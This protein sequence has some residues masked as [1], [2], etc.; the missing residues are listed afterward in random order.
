[1]NMFPS[2]SFSAFTK[3]LRAIGSRKFLIQRSSIDTYRRFSSYSSFQ[4]DSLFIRDNLEKFRHEHQEFLDLVKDHGEGSIDLIRKGRILELRINNPSKKN[5]I[6]GKMM[7]QLSQHFVNIGEEV[8]RDDDLIALVIRGEGQE[9]FAS[10]ADL[11]LVSQIL[12][13]SKKG[14]MMSHYMTPL[15]NTLKDCPLIVVAYLNG[16]VVGG[17][18]E[19]ATV[20]DFRIMVDKVGLPTMSRCE[21]ETAKDNFIQ[22]IHARLGA[23][24]GWGGG[25]RL[26]QIVGRRNALKFLGT[27]EKIGVQDALTVG[28]I[29]KIHTFST[30]SEIVPAADVVIEFLKPYL[31]QPYPKSVRAMKRIVSSVDGALSS[32]ASVETELFK[33]RWRSEDNIHA[34]TKSSKKK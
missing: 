29:D 24:P 30:N 31:D 8:A 17:G 21:K 26:T 12:N 3:L 4:K 25:S 32:A 22:F 23:S 9:S 6:S 1:M 16:Y 7:N 2:S 27:S 5:A 28:L 33:S 13:S 14:A 19:V 34:L 18:A 20:G 11:T 15:L 10:G